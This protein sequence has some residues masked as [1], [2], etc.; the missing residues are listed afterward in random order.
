MLKLIMSDLKDLLSQLISEEEFNNLSQSELEQK[1]FKIAL[2]NWRFNF[3]IWN[4]KEH[5]ND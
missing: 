2:S 3:N 4:P 1:I 5:K